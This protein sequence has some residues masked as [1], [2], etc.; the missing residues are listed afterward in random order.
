MR[1]KRVEVRELVFLLLLAALAVLALYLSRIEVRDV[2]S[3]ELRRL[4]LLAFRYLREK[5]YREAIETYNVL[6]ELKPDY[7]EGYVN[8]GNAHFA[9]GEAEKALAD[10]SKAI[11]LRPDFAE[12]YNN[13]GNAYLSLGRLEEALQDLSRACELNPRLSEAFFNRAIA[14]AEQGKHREAVEDL[15][16]C[17]ALNPSDAEALYYRALLVLRHRGCEELVAQDVSKALSLRPLDPRLYLL[18][19]TYFFQKGNHDRALEDFSKV[20]TLQRQNQSS[21]PQG[22]SPA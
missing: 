16:Q 12:A 2:F 22:H 3:P 4:V 9:L 14:L 20:I 15:T 6:L 5:R 19:G 21:L 17:I 8:R 18:R 10:Y 11:A 13:R 7:A 1:R